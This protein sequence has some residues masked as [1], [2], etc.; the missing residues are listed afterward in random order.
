MQ[1][2]IIIAEAGVNHN[3]SLK[4]AKQLV[5]VAVAAGVDYIK[6]QTFNTNKLV[7][8]N[9]EQAEYQKNQ[10]KTQSQ[11]EMLSKLELSKKQHYE[12]KA[13]C[14][15]QHIQFLSTAFDL[16]S[17]DFL[18]ELQVNVWKIPSGEITNAPYLIKIAQQKQPIIMST[19]M[20]TMHDI[21]NAL[22]LLISHGVSKKHITLL[23]CTTAYPTPFNEVNLRAMQ[24]IANHFGVSVGYS[25]HTLGIEVSLAAVAMGACVI[26]KHITLDKT[27]YGPDH[28][29]S[30]EPDE[31]H[32]MVRAIRNIEIAL[33]SNK[34]IIT[35]TESKNKHAA[36]KSIVAAQYIQKNDIF[37]ENNITTK[38]PGSG[39]S[40]MKW[41]EVIGKRAPQDFNP[42]ELIIL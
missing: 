3:G 32:A 41:N 35:A 26:E 37:T 39:I 36:R 21:E 33:G 28:A 40:P 34:K 38:R 1:N 4:I 10:T 25:D 30:I 13:Y 20:C 27:M 29:V 15:A 22:H 7:S 5:D 14:D 24:S 42:D 17:I 8:K 11:G 9:T 12:L 31:L 23:H 6:F 19:G 16:E 2:T 18:A